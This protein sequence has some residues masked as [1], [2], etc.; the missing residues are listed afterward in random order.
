MK[1]HI[2]DIYINKKHFIL[3]LFYISKLHI[4]IIDIC[5]MKNDNYY[6]DREGQK[7]EKNR[8]KNEFQSPSL[9]IH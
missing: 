6:S 9:R 8:A 7:R 2:V 5:L 3:Q 4:Y 1:V